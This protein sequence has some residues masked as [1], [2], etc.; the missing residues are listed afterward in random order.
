MCETIGRKTLTV[1]EAGEI[2]GISRQAAYEA[3]R[4]GQM[5]SLKIGSRISIPSVAIEGMLGAL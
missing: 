3:V 1:T 4:R 2:L 5:R